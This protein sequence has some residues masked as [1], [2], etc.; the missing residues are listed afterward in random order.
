[1]IPIQNVSLSKNLV[2]CNEMF[3]ISV[4]VIEQR[5][6]ERFPHSELESYSHLDLKEGGVDN[7]NND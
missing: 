4:T 7:G 6:L 3:T 5:W 1:M 2:E